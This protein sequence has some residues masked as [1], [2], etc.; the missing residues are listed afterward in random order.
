M[1]KGKIGYF[2]IVSAIIWGA[3]IIGCSLKL[4]GTECYNQISFILSIGAVSHLLFVW[5]PLAGQYKRIKNEK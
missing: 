4:Q 3:V 2:I 5:G 1:T